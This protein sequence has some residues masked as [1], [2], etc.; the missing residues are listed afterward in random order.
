MRAKVPIRNA[1]GRVIGLV[2]VGVL[3]TDAQR[4]FRRIAAGDPH[5]AARGARARRSL[6]ALRCSRAASKQQTFGLSRTRSA[7][8][9]S[10]ARRCCT[11]S[12]R[13]R[14][15][16]TRPDRI[17]L[18]NDEAQ[19][20]LGARRRGRRPAA[21]GCRAAR[22]A[23]ATCSP[24]EI[25]GPGRSHRPAATAC[26]SRTACRSS[27]AGGRSA[28]WSR[29]ATAP[30]STRSARELHDVRELAD[31]LRAQEHEFQH[32]LHVISGLIELGRYDD[33][34]QEINRSSR[35]PPGARRRRSSAAI[36]DP[37]ARRAAARQGRG[38]ERARRQARRL[39]PDRSCPTSS[40]TS[41]LARCDARQPDRQRDRLGI[42][43]VAAATS[44]SRSRR[45][46]RCLVDPRPRLRAAA[47][48]RR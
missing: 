19:R 35:P 47:S 23:S 42:Q 38:R 9:S 12:A 28:R 27:C 37:I 43:G 11:A 15:P 1:H 40:R 7:P 13:A 44:T 24:G 41:R 31:A 8:C 34:V 39:A 33:A 4:R 10:S 25:D 17:T 2:S 48:T 20:L 21:G 3:E 30:S 29:C 6:G 5:P 45:G 32:R 22:A 18:I 46:R 16:S 36:G 14:S 26:S